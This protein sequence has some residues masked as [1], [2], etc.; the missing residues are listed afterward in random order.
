MRIS[1]VKLCDVTWLF[2]AAAVLLPAVVTAAGLTSGSVGA[3]L[4]RRQHEH[5]HGHELSGG[6]E[7]PS[8]SGGDW[9]ESEDED[10]G[11]PTGIPMS[12]SMGTASAALSSTSFSSSAVSPPASSNAVAKPPDPHMH[13]HGSHAAVKEIL[14]DVGIHRWHDFP[15]TYL[16]ADFRLTADSAIFGEVFDET[17]DPENAS[18]HRGLMV[19]HVAA[20][21]LAYFTALPIGE[22]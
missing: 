18:G 6:P 21:I 19:I 1:G 12:M 8:S 13:S 2:L 14:D 3:S 20:M 10:V 22:S 9:D 5:E 17:W 16:A 11:S 4:A 15:P 7:H